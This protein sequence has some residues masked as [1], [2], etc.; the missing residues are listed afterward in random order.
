M[1]KLKELSNEEH[2]Q[3]LS[4]LQARNGNK[5]KQFTF[6]HTQNAKERIMNAL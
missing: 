1:K 4:A 5:A 3:I 2:R 6:E